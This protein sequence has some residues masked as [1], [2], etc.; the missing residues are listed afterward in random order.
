MAETEMAAPGVVRVQLLGAPAIAGPDG[1]EHALSA[2]D[3]ALLLMLW[4]G[5]PADRGTLLRL[6]WPRDRYRNPALNL[7]QHARRLGQRVGAPVVA[8]G[9]RP[10]LVSN[11]VVDLDD[12]P[13]QLRQDPQAAL[14]DVLAPCA[15]PHH[16]ELSAWVEGQRAAWRETRR[17]AL[18]LA[19]DERE[20]MQDLLGAA[21][22]CRRLCR[23]DPADEAAAC[24]LMRLCYCLPDLRAGL[25]VGARLTAALEQAYGVAPG[26]EARELMALLQRPPVS[27]AP[28]SGR[29]SPQILRPRT[30]VGRDGAWATLLEAQGRRQPVL[31]TGEAGIGKTRLLQDFA[32]DQPGAIVVRARPGDL[33]LGWAALSR[34]AQAL[35]ADDQAL[36]VASR[37]ELAR[38][39]PALGNPAPG[40][41]TPAGLT[42]ALS[43]ALRQRPAALVVVDDLHYA[44]A[45]SLRVLADLI[46]HMRDECWWLLSCRSADASPTLRHWLE[47]V[48]A[49]ACLPV[50]LQALSASHIE[51]LL[52]D[53]ALP[54]L[55][56]REWAQRL[57]QHSNGNVLFVLETLASIET[58]GTAIH[59][60]APLPVGPVV[61]AL[62]R[63]HLA[64]LSPAALR[65]ARLAALCGDVFD[66]ELAAQALGPTPH[67]TTPLDLAEP[68]IEL[69][70]AGI[71]VGG[72]LRHD[73]LRDTVLAELPAALA[74]AMHARIAALVEQRA[75][76]AAAV[77]AQHWAAAGLPADAA[78]CWRRHADQVKSQGLRDDELRA[79]DAEAACWQAAGEHR[80]FME[81]LDRASECALLVAGLDAGLVR[82]E[83]IRDHARDERD[84]VEVVL[85]RLRCELLAGQFD[86]ARETAQGLLTCTRR[87]DL[88]RA[89][90]VAALAL[91]QAQAM[92]GAAAQ[93]LELL[94]SAEITALVNTSADDFLIQEH[95]AAR[96][97]V[98]RQCGQIRLAVQ[99]YEQTYALAA[100]REDMQELM[101]MTG[102]LAVLQHTLGKTEAAW[103]MA[104]RA[105]ELRLR[106]DADNTVPLVAAEIQLSGTAVVIGRMARALEVAERALARAERIAPGSL[107]PYMA[108]ANLAQLWLTLA[109]YGRAAPLIFSS[110]WDEA[111]ALPRFRCALLRHRLAWLQGRRP[112]VEDTAA[113]AQPP[114]AAMPGMRCL[115]LVEQAL[116]LEPGPALEALAA[117]LAM[118]EAIE[119]DSLALHIRALRVCRLAEQDPLA[120]QPLALGLARDLDDTWDNYSMPE[121]WW[122]GC[123]ALAAAGEA[124][125]HDALLQRAMRWIEDRLLPHTPAPFRDTLRRGNPDVAALLRARPLRAA[126]VGGD[127]T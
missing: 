84:Q 14:G 1:R 46:E 76:L 26:A 91:A 92:T 39:L 108:K 119:S 58:E 63:R 31:V 37:S 85:S 87:L 117:A 123:R 55:R 50:P 89:T 102:N 95:A 53:L 3:A 98:L 103:H 45:D 38:L 122:C 5:R 74:T 105:C 113:L 52:D 42:A 97:L 41:A 73:T 11:V 9:E 110:D 21:E 83:T 116:L 99:A 47:A 36:P 20:Q 32:A 106:F 68:W 75:M 121:A 60:A 69:Q 59:P 61:Q 30:L 17:K 125:A 49:H 66:A 77:A 112:K 64:R 24:R 19:A 114:A 126:A 48:D 90:L 10:Q 70:Q 13:Q 28:R 65:L 88:P 62:Q 6:L 94:T 86:R 18:L 23:D 35:T 67:Q 71:L 2:D 100:A 79:R 120:A 34:L 16:E 15:Y 57:H 78:R 109:Q 27:P 33:D 40:P 44:D 93:G 107:W 43:D 96:G 82:A 104:E 29:R 51:H 101:T 111:P 8:V 127:A 22:C 80:H 4:Q 25:E 12:A 81:A 56:G 115:A 72:H 124:A 118:A 7:R 54:G